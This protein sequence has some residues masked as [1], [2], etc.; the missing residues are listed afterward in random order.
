VGDER[1]ACLNEDGKSDSWVGIVG[2]G[3]AA[4]KAS[5]EGGEGTFVGWAGRKVKEGSFRMAAL[6]SCEEGR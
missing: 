5:S 4:M 1:I 2:R 3:V 6:R